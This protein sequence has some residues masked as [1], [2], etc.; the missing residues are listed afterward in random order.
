MPLVI[1][2]TLYADAY[3]SFRCLCYVYVL[4]IKHLTSDYMS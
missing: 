3:V 1:I 4:D 2:K